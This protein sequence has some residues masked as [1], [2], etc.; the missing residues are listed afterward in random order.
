M[1]GG[2]RYMQKRWRGALL[3]AGLLALA[4]CMSAPTPTASTAPY[5]KVEA[6]DLTAIQTISHQQD[7]SIAKCSAIHDCDQA[8]FLKGLTALFEN[9]ELAKT[10]FQRVVALPQRNRFKTASQK[11]LQVLTRT[12]LAPTTSWLAKHRQVDE[13]LDENMGLTTTLEQMVRDL[14][15]RESDV[16][17]LLAARE[18]EAATISSLQQELGDRQRRIDELNNKKEKEPIKLPP[19]PAATAH[20]QAQIEQRDKKIAELTQQLD[21]LKR[22]D[23]ETREK[24][25]PIRPSPAVGEGDIKP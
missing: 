14:L 18:A 3:G 11:W 19:D 21:A 24:A 23:Q 10:Y 25:R 16:H 9:R 15:S 13:A 1:S 7:A 2:L 20:L 22:I 4:G 17:R 5:F 6:K 8:L 12:P